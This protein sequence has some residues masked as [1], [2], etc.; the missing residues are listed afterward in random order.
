META[1]NLS[2]FRELLHY[3]TPERRVVL[4]T[5]ALMLAGSLVTLA[6]PWLAGLLAASVL[7]DSDWDSKQLLALWLGVIA[8]SSLLGFF[9]S[10]RIGSTGQQLTANLRTRLYQHIQI[11]PTAYY[12]QRRPGETLTLLSSDAAIISSFVNDTLVRLLPALL[13]L[14]G[15]FTLM[16]WLDSTI[17]LTAL[18]FLPL[19]VLAMK[20]MARQLRPL[21]A[22]WMEA[23]SNMVSVVQ[24]NLDLLPTIKAFTREKHEQARFVKSNRNLLG[25]SL[26][27]LRAQSL[28]SPAIGFL[29]GIGLIAILW[30]GT[31]QIESG[32][33]SPSQM[34]SLLLYA[35]L[36]ISPLRTLANVYGQVQQMRGS[37]ERILRFLDECPEPGDEGRASLV[38]K[39]GAIEFQQIHFA[40]PER[41]P[42]FSNL[43]LNINA[44][45]T[46]AITGE[47]GV[48][49]TTLAHLLLRFAD[50]AQ[51]RILIDGVNTKDCTIVSVREHIG[52]VSQ[53]VQLL[54]DTVAANIAF[55]APDASET[56][57]QRAAYSAHALTFI[58]DLPKGFDTVI[59]DQGLKLSGGQRQRIS[60]ARALLKDP[61]ILIL[62]EATA[63][64][65]PAGERAFLEECREIFKQKTVLLITHRPASLEVADSVL[66]LLAGGSLEPTRC[67]QPELT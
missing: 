63:M 58:E 66:T 46:V 41:P 10:Y 51:G 64:F 17:A 32:R 16:T 23:N 33:L 13:T 18:V 19:Y 3:I 45:E 11:L 8:I 7:G 57:I 54:N 65:D 14:L 59:G 28:L 24:E 35:A 42:V 55:S 15:A 2:S 22:A 26:K 20:L 62:D 27:Q 49:K 43:N 12:Q 39:K 44:G 25:L 38:V 30:L 4:I 6:Q 50:P 56:A 34:V 9:T 1:T 31:T 5:L 37:A 29:A 61:P 67:S 21:S 40:Y 36:L 53:H 48:G 47:N 60:L 52:L